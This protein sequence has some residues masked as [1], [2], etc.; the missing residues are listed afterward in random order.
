[1]AASAPRP[2]LPGLAPAALCSAILLLSHAA[3][4][5]A[6]AADPP[7]DAE[8]NARV[9]VRAAS[10]LPTDPAQLLKLAAWA[11]RNGRLEEADAVYRRL[12]DEEPF[13]QAAREALFDLAAK[14]PL[15]A[16]SPAYEQAR[17]HLPGRFR[18]LQT[19]RFIV[20]SDADRQ[21]T[22][23]QAQRL[24]R[25]HH[26]F[27][28]F[29]RRLGLE[30]LPLRHKLV[31]VLF[32][33][34]EDY[35]HFARTEDEVADPWIAGYYAPKHDRVVFYRGEANPS[36]VEARAKLRE[37]RTEMDAL[38]REA[39][40]ATQEG[41]PDQ[42][43]V[44]RQQSRRYRDHLQRESE[45]VDA[46]A[47][48]VSTSTTVHETTHQ[49]LFHTRIQSPRIQY[50]IWISEGLATSFETDDTDGSFGPDHDYPTRRDAFSELLRSN[51]LI[52]LHGLVTLT[53]LAPTDEQAIHTVYQQSY[54]LVTWMNRF[55]RSEL[56]HYLELM[57]SEPPGP[58]GAERYREIFRDA[59][60]DIDRLQ[61]AWL[62]HERGH[63]DS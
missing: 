44:L 60:G 56:R 54:A 27:Q 43:E 50:P 21:W 6:P 29:A 15:P 63:L 18:E 7:S 9:E 32:A 55:R 48:Q 23:L 13:N 10:P 41:H 17:S 39:D 59:F 37:M 24:E 16:A 40:S 30:P 22:R 57:L 8:S 2:R 34:R 11:E 3:A 35:Q 61:R 53:R 38:A 14:R 47:D 5:P 51:D 58:I 19:R 42:A 45:R 33:D 12:L 49:L 25:T 1:M 36:V 31:C 62:T 26:Q 20:L 46:F 4:Y 28:R 52:D